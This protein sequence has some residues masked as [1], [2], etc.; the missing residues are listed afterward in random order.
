VAGRVEAIDSELRLRDCRT[1][2]RQEESNWRTDRTIDERLS[3]VPE[4]YAH[5]LDR[6][7]AAPAARQGRQKRK[8]LMRQL[9]FRGG[10]FMVD[11]T[12]RRAC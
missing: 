8:L 10:R 4:G 2:Q 1:A 9:C 7:G 12:N 3:S 11:S 6:K 5:D